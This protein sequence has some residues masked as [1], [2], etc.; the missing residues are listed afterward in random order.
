MKE[1]S[2]KEIGH[3]GLGYKTFIT[4]INPSKNFDIETRLGDVSDGLDIYMWS[5]DFSHRWTLASFEYYEK[6]GYWELHEVADRLT[7][8]NI[9]FIAFGELTRL[10]H[11]M[12]DGKEEPWDQ[13]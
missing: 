10:G 9:D 6:E 3:L 11:K 2:I 1:Y 8:P 5:E 7:D 12:L 4:K 13:I